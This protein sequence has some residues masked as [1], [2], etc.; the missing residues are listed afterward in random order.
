MYQLWTLGR[1]SLEQDGV[2]MAGWDKHRNGPAIL[3][4]L[5]AEGSV[6]RERLMAL[7]WPESDSARARG[8]LKQALHQV[9][10]LLAEFDV[11]QG[12]RVL[13]LNPALITT[14]I[15]QFRALL[16]GGH[17]QEAIA[18]YRG[19]FLEGVHLGGPPE[20]GHWIDAQRALF[21]RLAA[22]ALE[23]MAQ[24]ATE[25][26]DRLAATR[27]WERLAELEPAN[28][29]VTW[30]LLHA[31]EAA[32]NH[33]AALRAAEAHQ[34]RLQVDLELPPDPR[35]AQFI[36]RLRS[37]SPVQAPHV[38]SNG[39][40]PP[41]LAASVPPR[42]AP[43]Q[44]RSRALVLG[45]IILATA[46]VLGATRTLRSP[47]ARP[48]SA[49][50]VAVAPFQAVDTSLALWREGLAD[51]LI[52]DLD[53]A[54]PL[55]T[56]SGAVAFQHG[57]AHGANQADAL[58]IAE[59]TGAGIVVYGSLAR[60]G[61]D[62]LLIRARILDRP[63]GYLAEVELR[64]AESRMGALTDS[65]VVEILASLARNR[66]VTAVRGGTFGAT[67]LP[68][69]RE[70]L[71]GEQQYRRGS[72]DSALPRYERALQLEP[73]FALAMRRAAQVRAWGAGPGDVLVTQ[74]QLRS[75]AASLNRGLAP[76][77][78]LLLAAD[79]LSLTL[80]ASPDLSAMY[81]KRELFLSTLRE[82]ARRYPHDPEVFTELGE[83]LYHLPQPLGSAAEA[84]QV[85]DRAI[86]FDSGFSPAW[87]HVTELAF[88]LGQTDRAKAYARAALSSRTS[89]LNTSHAIATLALDSGISSAAFTTAL[90]G[91]SSNTL[92]RVGLDHLGWS[93][94]SAAAATVVLQQLALGAFDGAW[95]GPMVTDPQI[96]PRH[97]AAALAF[98]GRITEAATIL[99]ADT[100][101][102]RAHRAGSLA[103]PYLEVA[104]MGGIPPANA[105][106]QFARAF[107]DRDPWSARLEP[108]FHRAVV[109]APWWYFQ[110]DTTM[111]RRLAARA[112]R[113]A[114]TA[115]PVATAPRARYIRAAA[116]AWLDLARGDTAAAAERLAALPDSLCMVALCFYEKMALARLHMAAGRDS[117]ARALYSTWWTS[118]RA[119]PSAVLASL[120]M[121][122]L[123]ERMD[124]T[125][126]A[127]AHYRFVAEAWQHAD[128]HLMPYADSARAALARLTST[129]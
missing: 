128:P 122:Q 13:T 17:L 89:S 12:E 102:P 33:A 43:P 66:P 72:Y 38:A 57:T 11:V 26:H 36:D 80:G 20:L 29:H 67:S 73:G 23:R 53:G 4:I 44:P 119:T 120:D 95:A 47:G 24:Q 68:A 96:R 88:R 123:A 48:V 42:G 117:A 124:D 98:R 45:A 94:D 49:D 113:I 86:A 78:S 99:A 79:D 81:R 111:L 107:S 83:A 16:A 93:T 112:R 9:R 60:L 63:T 7:L 104:L 106:E 58:Q 31:Y 19:H 52:R 101:P 51:M 30:Q 14:D 100:A 56:V 116:L 129:R 21:A 77:D 54:G 22:D 103:D 115:E 1:F 3:A 50:L 109:S 87:E 59:R 8:S 6:S 34:R 74:G 76:R 71:R 121:A 65:L 70:F 105:R 61:P 18:R 125:A 85:F 28:T 64:G 118:A 25:R 91:A 46:L 97:W 110:R 92:L 32:G 27:S 127:L 40:P 39:A 114:D 82:A 5:A 15:G 108:A 10:Q 69:L 62:S 35:I 41:A 2:A 37:T 84:L 55:T 126:A 75:Q 90:A